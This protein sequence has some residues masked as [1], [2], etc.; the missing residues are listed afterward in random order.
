MSLADFDEYCGPLTIQEA[1]ENLVLALTL[2]GIG[3]PDIA[4]SKEDLEKVTNALVSSKQRMVLNS[5]D[6]AEP[7]TLRV[8]WTSGGVINFIE[9]K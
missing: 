6:V 2:E 9:K 4:F 5:S 1:V 7:K 8:N 3:M